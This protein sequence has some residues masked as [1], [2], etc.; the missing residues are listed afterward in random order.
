[1]PA[2]PLT[3]KRETVRYHSGIIKD[4]KLYRNC[5]PLSFVLILGRILQI[6]KI[7]RLLIQPSS[8]PFRAAAQGCHPGQALSLKV[9]GAYRY[10]R[11]H[12]ITLYRIQNTIV[13]IPN[14]RVGIFSLIR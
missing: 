8:F 14:R 1:M 7:T 5:L 13:M 4:L 2:L 11:T 10:T 9:F 6:L 3:L 12:A